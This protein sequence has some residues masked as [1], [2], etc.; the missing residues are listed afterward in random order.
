MTS[1]DAQKVVA[2]WPYGSHAPQFVQSY[3][4]LR[5][6]DF[7][8]HQRI[9]ARIMLGTSNVA[10]GRNQIVRMFLDL[11]GR[12]DWLWF[13]DT[14]MAFDRD[15]LDRMVA[16]AHPTKRPILG[17]LCF[18]VLRGDAQQY[19]P[20]LYGWTDDDP[21]RIGRFTELP[22]K[23]A[24]VPVAATGT[25]CLLIHRTVLEAVA[26]ME[27]PGTSKTYGETSYPWFRFAEWEN[28]ELGADVMGEDIV[29]CIRAAAAGF[30][31]HVD[32]GIEVGHVKPHVVGVADYRLERSLREAALISPPADATV[33]VIPMKDRADLTAA[34][35]DDLVAQGEVTR[36]IVMDNGSTEPATA[37]WFAS[38]PDRVW[39]VDAAGMN[40]H[41][42]WN[43]GVSRALSFGERVNV[44]ILNNDIEVGPGFLSGL[45]DALRSDRRLLAVCPNYDDRPGTGV[46]PVEGICADRYDGTGGLSGFAFMVPG[47]MFAKGFPPFDETLEWFFGDNDFV[48]TVAAFGGRMGLVADVSCHHIGSQ[49]TGSSTGAALG[50]AFER[51]KA[52][53]LAKWGGRELEPWERDLL[54]VNAP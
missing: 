28:D 46:L 11:P 16:A 6:Y 23:P 39:V 14:D 30:P 40:L 2:A 36:I 38:L 4:D 45:G 27:V 17:A 47:E 15:T 9:V 41:Q 19:V 8:N 24:V 18:S 22:D 42:M 31:T 50:D 34:L 33:A 20:T 51:D 52:T 21:P 48:A 1:R 43:A 29:F 35:V 13:V 5:Q 49:T 7:A 54:D 32:T 44:A 10:H 53:F 12:P 25:G 3:D 37:E 26:A